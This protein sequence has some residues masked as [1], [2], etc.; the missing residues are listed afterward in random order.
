MLDF[1][2][3]ALKVRIVMKITLEPLEAEPSRV[4]CLVLLNYMH[5]SVEIK[6]FM[7]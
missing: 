4:H 5:K 7:T 2:S 6:K 1:P 3:E